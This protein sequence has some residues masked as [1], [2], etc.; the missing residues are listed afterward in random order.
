MEMELLPKRAS[1]L[2]SKWVGETEQQM[3]AAFAE[4]VETGS[5]LVFDEADSLLMDREYAVRSWETSMVN[6]L[7]SQMERH[8]LPFAC[9]TNRREALDPAAARR[10]QFRVELFYMDRERVERAFRFF[11]GC[12]APSGALELDRLTPGDFA[13]VRERAKI[14]DFLNDPVR[15]GRALEEECRH[16]PGVA[17][18]GF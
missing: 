5:F 8:P 18:L 3:A 1:D 15:I 10:F 6:E 13:N 16:K 7:L 17:P 11:Y 9:T 2:L 14:L 4:A 12:E